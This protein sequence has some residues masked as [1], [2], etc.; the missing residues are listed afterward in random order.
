[1]L[2]T[3][4]ESTVKSTLANAGSAA[5]T[6]ESGISTLTFAKC[7]N[8]VV[9]LK[10]GKA[11]L[12]HIAGTDNGTLTTIGTEVTV[13]VSPFGSCIYGTG[14]SLDAGVTEGGN[15]GR[16]K[17]NVVVP[18]VGGGFTCPSEARVTGEYTATSPTNAWVAAG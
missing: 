11:E 10:P 14:A 2:I 17:L 7:T 4:T 9:V 1:M 6:V 12:H 3:C 13:N 18:K 8:P 5:T 15:P 16:M